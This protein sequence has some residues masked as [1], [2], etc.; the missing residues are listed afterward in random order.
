MVIDTDDSGCVLVM[1]PGLIFETGRDRFL[2][3]GPD[4]KYRWELGF[5]GVPERWM[6]FATC[7]DRGVFYYCTD[8][9]DAFRCIDLRRH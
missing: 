2:L 1:E 9:G 7:F 8:A 3:Y 4:F 6:S 5:V